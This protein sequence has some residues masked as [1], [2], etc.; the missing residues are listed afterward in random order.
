MHRLRPALYCLAMVL[1]PT[2]WPANLSAQSVNASLND[3]YYHWIDRYE[4][5]SGK[6]APELFTTIKPYKRA[7][8]VAYVDSLE[9]RSGVFKSAADKFNYDYLRNDSWEWSRAATSDSRKPVMKYIYR[10]KSDFANVDIPDFDFHVSPVLYFS[11]GMDSK[12]ESRPWI[13]LRGL[14]MRGMVDRKVGFYAFIGENQSVLPSYVD[15]EK[16]RTLAVQHEG[17]WKGFKTNGVDFFQ[18]RG[19]IDFNISKH[20]YMQFGHDR[21]FLGNGVRSLIWSDWAP[22]QL[23]MRANVKVWKLNYL[24][25]LNRM[26]ADVNGSPSGLGGGKYP[27]KFVALHHVSFNIGKK[28]NLGLFESVVFSPADSVHGGSFEWNYL[29]PVIFYRAIEHQFGSSDNVLLG[30]DFKLNLVRNVSFYGQMVIDEFLWGEVKSGNGWWANKFAFQAGAKYINAFGVSNLDLLA[31]TNVVRPYTY[32][33]STPFDS[34]SNYRQSIAHPTGANFREL[35]GTIRYQPLGR[36][37]LTAKVFYTHTGKDNTGEDWG[38]DILKSNNEREMEHGNKTGQGQK[39]TILLADFT[40]S[41][42]IAH[43]LF[44]DL[45]QVIRKSDSDAP[46]YNQSMSLT[47]V[48]L[49]LNVAQRNYDF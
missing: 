7:W 32:S 41:Y 34:Y 13:N 29:N 22:P 43:N 39:T 30:A 20:I 26:V 47:S 45:K 10:K 42:M 49:R 25:Q 1:A 16:N 19:Y 31:E 11:G 6:I 21:M 38:G 40:A 23:Y 4:V 2:F 44:V 5:A 18:A 8:I 9:K 12:S 24:F 14:E 15:A 3:D 46:Q 37:N 33:H 17:F 35:I 48:A 36:L 28:L 27:D